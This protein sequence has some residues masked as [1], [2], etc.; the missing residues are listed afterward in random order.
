M[1]M[2]EVVLTSTE[3]KGFGVMLKLGCII[4]EEFPNNTF[5]YISKR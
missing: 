5:I 1:N 4:T 2:S 3:W